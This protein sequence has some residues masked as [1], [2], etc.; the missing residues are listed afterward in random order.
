M[1]ND[2]TIQGLQPALVWEEPKITEYDAKAEIQGAIPRG[3]NETG[4]FTS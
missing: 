3:P 4:V 1:E 2:T